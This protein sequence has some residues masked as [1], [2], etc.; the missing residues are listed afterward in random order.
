MACAGWFA[1][2]NEII[3]FNLQR[4][5]VEYRDATILLKKACSILWNALAPSM[6]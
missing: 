3:S 2:C 1:H 5:A 4:Y 6:D